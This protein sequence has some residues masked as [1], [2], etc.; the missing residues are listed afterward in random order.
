MQPSPRQ[1]G[2]TLIEL[3]VVVAIAAILLTAGVGSFGELRQRHT[4]EGVARELA[5]DLQYVRA[6]AVS[7]SR[8]VR[9]SL[10]SPAGGSCYVIHTGSAGD[11]VCGAAGPA[12]C[13]AGA[14]SLKTVFL[15]AERGVAVRANRASLAYSPVYGTTSPTATLRVEGADGRAIHHRVNIMGRARSCSPGRSMPGY[16]DCDAL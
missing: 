1:R 5:I 16:A 9:L 2:F 8:S 12:V 4:L 6:E 3:G 7:R 10:Q 13:D 11:C 14:E 15:P